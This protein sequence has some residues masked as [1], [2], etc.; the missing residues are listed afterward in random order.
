MGIKLWENFEKLNEPQKEIVIK[1]IKNSKLLLKKRILNYSI[2]HGKTNIW[3]L[4]PH[5]IVSTNHILTIEVSKA[6]N[7]IKK[8]DKNINNEIII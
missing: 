3:T 7:S 4:T 6:K 8:R 5:F 1:K 2:F